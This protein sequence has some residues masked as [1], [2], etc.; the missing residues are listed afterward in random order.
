MGVDHFRLYTKGVEAANAH[1]IIL[2]RRRIELDDGSFLDD[3]VV[4][5]DNFVVFILL[6]AD[7]GACGIDDA[8]LPKYNVAHYFIET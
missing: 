5:K 7:D 8:A 4:P 6:L 2:F 1:D 3:I